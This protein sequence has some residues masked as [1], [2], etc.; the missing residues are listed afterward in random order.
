MN[1]D[2]CPFVACSLLPFGEVPLP[3]RTGPLASRAVRIFH[4]SP[5]LVLTLKDNATLLVLTQASNA[6]YLLP[7]NLGD[8]PGRDNTGLRGIYRNP[9]SFARGS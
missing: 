2:R 5:L 7:P 9:G 4:P 3:I 8:L 6:K 1:P